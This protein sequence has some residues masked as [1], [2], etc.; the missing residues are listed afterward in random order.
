MFKLRAELLH[1]VEEPA[2]EAVFQLE[3]DNL[4]VSQVVEDLQGAVL[5]YQIQGGDVQTNGRDLKEPYF[6]V[7]KKAYNNK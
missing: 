7:K 2:S 3:A 4:Q 5:S 1:E 6:F